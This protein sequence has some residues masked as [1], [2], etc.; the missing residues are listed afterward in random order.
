MPRA[1]SLW[2]RYP[3]P[4]AIPSRATRQTIEVP[5]MRGAT[6]FGQIFLPL[7]IFIKE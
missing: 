6:I 1:T 2:P 7:Y 4:L 3:L 5:G